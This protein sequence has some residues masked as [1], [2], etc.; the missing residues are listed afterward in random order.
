MSVISWKGVVV[1]TSLSLTAGKVAIPSVTSGGGKGVSRR[2]GV[3]GDFV[4][5]DICSPVQ[6]SGDESY[7]TWCVV[8]GGYRGAMGLVSPGSGN[9]MSGDSTEY[10]IAFQTLRTTF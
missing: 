1:S 7:S 6:T 4:E 3:E 2:V 9:A 8:T 10:F 5:G